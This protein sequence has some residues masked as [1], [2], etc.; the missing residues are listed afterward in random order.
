MK[1]HLGH[2]SPPT[3]VQNDCIKLSGFGVNITKLLL[4]PE[5][6][7]NI[8]CPEKLFNQKIFLQVF[9]TKITTSSIVSAVLFRAN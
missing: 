5:I 8:L 6:T 9:R 2:T 7:R 1:K 4:H 3:N